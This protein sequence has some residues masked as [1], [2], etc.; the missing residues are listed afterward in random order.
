MAKARRLRNGVRSIFS[1]HA[2][3]LSSRNKVKKFFND[4]HIVFQFTM[5]WFIHV[6][7]ILTALAVTAYFQQRARRLRLRRCGRSIPLDSFPYRLER[8]S[9]KRGL[10][11]LQYAS[12]LDDLQVGIAD[13]PGDCVESVLVDLIVYRSRLTWA[14]SC[15]PAF[16]PA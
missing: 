6:Y 16:L 7:P 11:A 13:D 5:T 9:V 1:I 8:L 4:R 12:R 3:N 15:S 2:H 10:P 14:L